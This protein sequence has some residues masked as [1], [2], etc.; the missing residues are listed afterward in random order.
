[1]NQSEWTALIVAIAGILGGAWTA[2]RK[3]VQ[4][5]RAD[6]LRQLE[7]ARR[8]RDEA[9]SLKDT[10]MRENAHVTALIGVL[11]RDLAD[12]MHEREK[13]LPLLPD[14]IRRAVDTEFMGLERTQ[15]LRRK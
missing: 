9:V 4:S 13:L 8:D 2:V 12:A 11:E 15:P 6:A 5:E 1:M 7:K 14:E 10:L 3:W